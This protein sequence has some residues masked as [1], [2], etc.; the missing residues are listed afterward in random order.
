MGGQKTPTT[1]AYCVTFG[2][3][4]GCHEGKYTIVSWILHGNPPA[5]FRGLE[6]Q[7]KQRMAKQ[8]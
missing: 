8:G 1:V 7:L 4:Y 3:F 6:V 2:D 5:F